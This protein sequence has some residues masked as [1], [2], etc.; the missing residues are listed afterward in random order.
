MTPDFL[1]INDDQ[2]SIV[3]HKSKRVSNLIRVQARNYQIRKYPRKKDPQTL[4]IRRLFPK[5]LG[6]S[7]LEYNRSP[8]PSGSDE[9]GGIKGAENLP[10]KLDCEFHI[11]PSQNINPNFLQLRSEDRQLIRFYLLWNVPQA[12]SNLSCTKSWPKAIVRVAFNSELNALVLTCYIA[13]MISYLSEP[14][15]TPQQLCKLRQKV[16]RPAER[17]ICSK[18]SFPWDSPSPQSSK[19]F[20]SSTLPIFP[21]TTE[22]SDPVTSACSCLSDVLEFW[23]DCQVSDTKKTSCSPKPATAITDCLKID[24]Q[25]NSTLHMLRSNT[26]QPAYFPMS[27]NLAHLTQTALCALRTHLSTKNE[28]SFGST[29]ASEFLFPVWCLFRASIFQGDKLAALAHGRF[30]RH[31]IYRPDGSKHSP[32]RLLEVIMEVDLQL[33]LSG[34]DNISC[35]GRLS[36]LLV[37][38]EERERRVILPWTTKA[39]LY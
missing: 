35:D 1:F 2:S 13:S 36:A 22:V 20:G 4:H 37:Q 38:S 32:S 5:K 14:S 39:G 30:L 10:A 28:L 12:Y 31:L 6:N 18:S 25:G 23:H 21:H 9:E 16:P 11:A 29:F 8:N 33:R 34:L 3:Q 15:T 24:F 19:S 27:I 7:T 26:S 17:L